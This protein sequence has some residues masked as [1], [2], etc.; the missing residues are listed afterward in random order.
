MAIVSTD[1]AL[2]SSQLFSKMSKLGVDIL[3]S[4]GPMVFLAICLPAA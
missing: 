4:A 3:V 2:N 1:G